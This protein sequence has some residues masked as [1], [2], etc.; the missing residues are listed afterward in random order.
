MKKIIVISLALFLSAFAAQAQKAPLTVTVDYKELFDNYWKVKED[1]SKFQSSVKRTQEMLD[2]L[3]EERN[4]LG[5]ELEELDKKSKSPNMSETGKAEA[6]S[7]FDTKFPEFQKKTRELEMQTQAAQQNIARNRQQII[8]VHAQAIRE[9]VAEVAKGKGAD[10]VLNVTNNDIVLY[11]SPSFDITA[12][13]L[14]VLNADKP[15]E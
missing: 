15:A 14:N 2:D 1:E 5:K 13:V 10:L 11:V 3:K 8:Q 4:V 12:E 6:K 7:E 9:V